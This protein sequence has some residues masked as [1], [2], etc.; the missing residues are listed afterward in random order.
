MKLKLECNEYV[1]VTK[2][3]N[4]PKG[5]KGQYVLVFDLGRGVKVLRK[6]KAADRFE[7][8]VGVGRYVGV[9]QLKIINEIINND[10]RFFHNIYLNTRVN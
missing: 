8:E 5:V 9:A 6:S 2:V 4:H 3:A 1:T 7:I 10:D